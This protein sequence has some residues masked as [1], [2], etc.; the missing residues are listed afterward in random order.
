MDVVSQAAHQI[1]A[2]NSSEAVVLLEQIQDDA[3]IMHEETRYFIE[4]LTVLKEYYKT[5][6]KV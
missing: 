1:K 5:E 3:H 6:V 4:Q 2:G